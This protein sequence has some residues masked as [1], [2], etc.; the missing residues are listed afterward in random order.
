[1]EKARAIGIKVGKPPLKVKGGKTLDPK[2]ILELK[3]QGQ[4]A[5]AIAKFLGCSVTPVL[6]IINAGQRKN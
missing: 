6:R 1:M 4:S 5:R 2:K 3:A